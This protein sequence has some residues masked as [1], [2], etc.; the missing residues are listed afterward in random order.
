MWSTAGLV[1]DFSILTSCK[2]TPLVSGS[3]HFFEA[4]GGK[5]TFLKWTE[6]LKLMLTRHSSTPFKLHPRR[7]A[8]LETLT[9][10]KKLF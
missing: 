3:G 8:C 2:C 1:S 4:P 10:L 6:L 5:L 9:A 7:F